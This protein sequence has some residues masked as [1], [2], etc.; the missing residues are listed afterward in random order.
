MYLLFELSP[1]FTQDPSALS[2]RCRPLLHGCTGVG[3]AVGESV[4][5]NVGETVGALLGAGVGASVGAGL[6]DSVGTAVG[7]I[8][9]AGVGAGVASHIESV[10]SPG[11]RN[12][13]PALH[14]Q[15]YVWPFLASVYRLCELVPGLTQD[16]CV[17]SH[18]WSPLSQGWTAVG[19]AVGALV[20]SVQSCT[21]P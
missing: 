21:T 10:A 16:P 19:A 17:L 14:S 2:Q 5:V 3:E 6:G 1:G 12:T 20:G 4:G 13:Y 7:E 8:V 11:L 18:R 15:W 9:G